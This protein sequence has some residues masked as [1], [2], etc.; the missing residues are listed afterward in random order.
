MHLPAEIISK[1]WDWIKGLGSNVNTFRYT[2]CNRSHANIVSLFCC[3]LSYL[4]FSVWQSRSKHAAPDLRKL[5][6]LSNSGLWRGHKLCVSISYWHCK[7]YT[8]I[9]LCSWLSLCLSVIT[10]VQRQ[11]LLNITCTGTSAITQFSHEDTITHE[12]TIWCC[13]NTFNW[14]LT[15]T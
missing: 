15:K 7:I 6:S 11:E 10:W 2:E 1:V 8:M 5:G 4:L 13:G 9:I 3:V 12:A 14:F